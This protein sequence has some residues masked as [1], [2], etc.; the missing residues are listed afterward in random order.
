MLY[1]VKGRKGAWLGALFSET[2]DLVSSFKY[3]LFVRYVVQVYCVL[4]GSGT[5]MR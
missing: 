1:G 4:R 2:V 3:V 5:M